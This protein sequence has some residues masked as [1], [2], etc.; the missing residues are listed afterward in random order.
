MIVLTLSS[1]QANILNSYCDLLNIDKENSRKCP[2]LLKK[3]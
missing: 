2:K 1:K 3:G